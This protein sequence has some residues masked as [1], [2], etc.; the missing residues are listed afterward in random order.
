MM[1]HLKQ[2]DHSKLRYC[3]AVQHRTQLAVL[4]RELRFTWR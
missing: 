4:W 1:L 2:C 3:G